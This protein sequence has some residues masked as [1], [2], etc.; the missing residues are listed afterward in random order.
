MLPAGGTETLAVKQSDDSY[1]L[2]GHKWFSSATDADTALTLARICSEDGQ[3]TEVIMSRV[4]G[5]SYPQINWERIPI[6]FPHFF[7]ILR[8]V[9]TYPPALNK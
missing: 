2:Y 7:L 8:N 5:A 1:K 6:S 4:A 9:E 3:Y